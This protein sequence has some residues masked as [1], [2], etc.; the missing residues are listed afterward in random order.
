MKKMNIL[1]LLASLCLLGSCA[2]KGD[3]NDGKYTVTFKMYDNGLLKTVS[4]S[5][6]EKDGHVTTSAAFKDATTSANS[7]G[8]NTKT[9]YTFN[10][11]AK[12][13]AGKNEADYSS[14]SSN[15]FVIFNASTESITGDLTL[16]AIFTT[17]YSYQVAFYNEDRKT[18]LQDATY[19]DDGQKVKYTGSTPTKSNPETGSYEFSGWKTRDGKVFDL[20]ADT[21]TSPT[22]L[23]ADYSLDSTPVISIENTN[24]DLVCSVKTPVN[25]IITKDYLENILDDNWYNYL[26]KEAY[27]YELKDAPTSEVKITKNL[28]YHVDTIKTLS[29]AKNGVFPQTKVTDETL[30]SKIDDAIISNTTDS[31]GYYVVDGISYSKNDTTY[32]KVEP[33]KWIVIDGSWSSEVTLLSEKA[34]TSKKYNS[35]ISYTI[36]NVTYSGYNYEHSAI[37]AWL[38]GDFITNSFEDSSLLQEKEIDNTKDSNL[39]G[40]TSRDDMFNNY[41]DGN[42]KNTTDKA[43]LLS[44]TEVSNINGLAYSY[45]DTTSTEADSNRI[46]YDVDGN[47]VNY[48][49][50]TPYGG[51]D[52]DSSN[53]YRGYVWIVQSD[54]QTGLIKGS[55]GNYPSTAVCS[56][57]F[58]IRP[59]V[60][61]KF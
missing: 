27:Y 36:D 3:S 29:F 20:N 54:G 30:I 12:L 22:Q 50:R 41:F 24:G 45:F 33:I 49:L 46:T 38:N 10:C 18:I 31:L 40:N 23:F 53:R 48:F 26:K 61:F 35:E 44:R 4:T 47:A 60:S 9:T 52:S 25:T 14:L 6:V 56:N 8:L 19:V 43:W 39:E 55:S 37:R 42:A 59:V 17:S 16:Y 1:P 57:T 21:I 11:W 13:V 5:T 7:D 28:T 58:G 15:D 32:R 51:Y 34:L 2:K